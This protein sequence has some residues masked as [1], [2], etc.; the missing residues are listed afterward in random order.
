MCPGNNSPGKFYVLWIE[1]DLS[2]NPCNSPNP[3]VIVNRLRGWKSSCGRRWVEKSDYATKAGP[4]W[5]NPSNFGRKNRERER[6]HRCSRFLIMWDPIQ[7]WASWETPLK[8]GTK[9]GRRNWSDLPNLGLW[10]S[11]TNIP[12]KPLCKVILLW[13]SH[14]DKL[15]SNMQHDSKILPHVF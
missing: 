14:Y 10:N 11:R 15:L 3:K 8:N 12:N 7:P 5:L 1:Y 9:R 6:E 13:I 4:S 2:I